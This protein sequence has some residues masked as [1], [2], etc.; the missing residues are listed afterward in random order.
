MRHRKQHNNIPLLLAKAVTGSLNESEQEALKGWLEESRENILLYREVINQPLLAKKYDEY[1]AVDLEDAYRKVKLRQKKQAGRLR[2]YRL[3]SAAA[4]LLLLIGLTWWMRLPEH[5]GGQLPE[6]PVIVHGGSKA[7]LVLSDGTRMLLDESV[8]DSLVNQHGSTIHVNGNTLS[9]RS[10]APEEV[11]RYNELKVPRG[12][13]FSI[14]L[15]DGTVVYVNS[16]TSLHYPVTF[17]GNERKVSLSGEAFFDVKQDTTPFRIELDHGTVIE[18]LGTS[19]NIRAYRDESFQAATLVEGKVK[20]ISPLDSVELAPGEQALLSPEGEIV[21]ENVDTYLYT[22]WK[23]GMFV[24]EEQRME[25]IMNNLS[26]WYDINL[27]WQHASLKEIVFSGKMLRYDDFSK[28]IRMLE[29][30]GEIKFSIQENN[31]T[32]NEK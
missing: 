14:T 19:F 4:A 9:Y 23:E 11:L 21:R 26:R 24:F 1:A 13:E 5:R 31:I 20:I 12:G 10:E 16:E 28:I 6:S 3:S 32:I 27:S 30:T 22:A 8:I 29:M 25:D 15:S 7:E 2:F 17:G 18:V